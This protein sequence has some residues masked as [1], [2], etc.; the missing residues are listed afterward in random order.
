MSPVNDAALIEHGTEDICDD[1]LLFLEQVPNSGLWIH[2]DSS[3][4]VLGIPTQFSVMNDVI[5]ILTNM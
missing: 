2:F 1:N 4:G 5:H 3:V